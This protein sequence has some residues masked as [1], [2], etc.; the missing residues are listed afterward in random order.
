MNKII[1]D[2]IVNGE[3][4]RIHL[5]CNIRWNENDE[6]IPVIDIEAYDN[7]RNRV[8]YGTGYDEFEEAVKVFSEHVVWSHEHDA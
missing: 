3:I 8:F 5:Y 7:K 2:K 4:D 6:L 1:A